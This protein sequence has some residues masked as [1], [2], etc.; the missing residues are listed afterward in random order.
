M[1][2]PDEPLVVRP[3]LEIA[4]VELEQEQM[5]VLGPVVQGVDVAAL[6]VGMPMELVV[7]TLSETA[8][9]RHLSWKWKPAP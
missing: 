1:A 9:E 7:E 8:T 4:A 3:G 2:E 6:T 5:I